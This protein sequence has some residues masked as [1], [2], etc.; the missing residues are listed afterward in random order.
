MS[1]PTLSADR[2]D[3]R[4]GRNPA[5]GFL[6]GAHAASQ[7]GTQISRV[8]LPLVAVLTLHA[9]AAEVG[10]L[11]AAQMLGYLVIGLPA[12]VWVDGYSKRTVMII[13]DLVRAAALLLVPV[14]AAVGFL[15]LW[16][17]Y[18]A[19]VVTGFA[20]VLFG[21]STQSSLPALVGPAHLAEANVRMETV[22]TGATLIAPTFAGWLIQLL[23]AA[24]VLFIDV[25][26]YLVSAV[27]LFAGRRDEPRLREP[28]TTNLV[29]DIRDG[30]DHVIGHP[31]LRLLALSG[32]IVSTTSALLMAVEVPYLVR[33]VHL[34][35]VEI[36]L[37]FTAGSVGAAVGM[38]TA[39]RLIAAFGVER[40]VWLSAVAT[41]PFV[42][43]L[44]LARPG[45][46][47]WAYPV[48]WMIVSAGVPTHYMYQVI[49]RQSITPNHL[50]GRVNATFEF[51]R[52]A[53]TSFGALI[54]GGIGQ[55]F[56]LRAAIWVSVVGILISIIPLL[57]IG[58]LR[59]IPIE[60]GER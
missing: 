45:W 57:K 36:G 11:V 50:L 51:L 34:Q 2:I 47:A 15:A 22:T 8:A 30:L 48:G 4:L 25:A 19:A 58:R 46:A 35:S 1:S 20:S 7:L 29:S 14:A 42:I 9:S 59:Q 32:L 53:P 38:L 39:R 18:L 10:V 52:F 27:L 16:Q 54:G 31:V 6:L 26:S 56:G 23:S 3:D 37:V 55:V 33:D 40:M 13:T 28:R 43:L 60:G 21:V 49:L 17:L 12:G 24:S 5:F 44:G 41:W